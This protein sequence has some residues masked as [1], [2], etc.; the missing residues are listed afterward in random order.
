MNICFDFDG[1]IHSATAP[2]QCEEIILGAPVKGCR[3]TLNAIK[4]KG[5]RI[6]VH[7]V[8]CRSSKGRKAIAKYMYANQLEYDK[9][10]QHKPIADFYI[11][12]RAVLFA[13]N[14]QDVIKAMELS[15]L[16]HTKKTEEDVKKPE[17]TLKDINKLNELFKEDLIEDNS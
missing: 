10:S 5:Y 4:E 1:V 15:R 9:I 11:D 8:R 3:E 16:S 13:G 2:W 17:V 14:W 7:S 6:I 12:D